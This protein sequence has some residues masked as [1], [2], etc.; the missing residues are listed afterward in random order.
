MDLSEHVAVWQSMIAATLAVNGSG[1]ILIILA[2]VVVFVVFNHLSAM[3]RAS[4]GFC[5]RER[6]ARCERYNYLY[7]FF[8]T[9]SF[10]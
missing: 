10:S 4:A 1:W 2:A 3:P 6:L 8:Q 7:R 5:L 9:V